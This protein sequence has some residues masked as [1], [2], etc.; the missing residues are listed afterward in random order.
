MELVAAVAPQRIEQIAGEARRV[1]PDQRCFDR[2]E[3]AH[4]DGDR[5]VARLVLDAVADDPAA[6]V[7]R[8]Q[9]GLGDAVT[10]FSR[11]RRYLISDSIETIGSPCSRA[12]ACSRSR[13]A[14]PRA[15]EDLAQDAGRASSR[16]AGPGRPSPRYARRGGARPPPWPPAGNRWPGRTRSSGRVAGSMIARTV[17]A[18]SSA[19]MPVRHDDVIDRHRVRRLVRGRIAVDHRAEMKPRGNF[20]QDRHAHQPAAVRD[21]ELDRLGR[22]LLGRRDKIALVLPVFVVDDDDDPPFPEG[23]EGVVDLR[24]FI[25]HGRFPRLE[26]TWTGDEG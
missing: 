15:V 26:N 17:R 5:L 16:P 9:I 19:L 12:I 10:S 7:A 18:R 13:L 23:L 11:R 4:D 14:T 6:A 20:G 21:H 1:Q 25:V 8:R 24:E 22:D 2:P 3:V